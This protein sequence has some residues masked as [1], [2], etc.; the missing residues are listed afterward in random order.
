MIL[1]ALALVATMVSAEY[2]YLG[3]YG[4][5]Y[6]SYGYGYSAYPSYGYS[7]YYP[8]SYGGYGYGRYGGYGGAR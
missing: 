5:Y 8:A 2:G 4:S 3:S 7:S 1:V 6:P